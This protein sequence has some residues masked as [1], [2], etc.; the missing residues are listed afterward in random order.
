MQSRRKP[1]AKRT[2]TQT[3]ACRTVAK[4]EEDDLSKIKGVD[5]ALCNFHCNNELSMHTPHSIVYTSEILL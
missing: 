3:K 5:T 1:K 2:E 4:R